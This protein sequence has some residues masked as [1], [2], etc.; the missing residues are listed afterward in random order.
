MGRARPTHVPDPKALG[1]RLRALREARG[2]SLRQIAFPGCSPSYLSRVESGDRVASLTIL[3]ELARRLGTTIE[4]LLGRSIDGRISDGDLA[5][6]EV[7]ARM[8][9]PKADEDI[10]SLLSGARSLGD[11]RAESRL[12]EFQ[13]LLALDRRDEARAVEL[14]EQARSTGPAASARERPALF[15][16]LGRAYTA[17]G[18]LIQAASV[19]QTAFDQVCEAPPDAALMVQFGSYLADAYTD[20][21]R[22]SDAET[23]LGRVLRHDRD[24][25]SADLVQLDW[26]LA[27]TYAEQGESRVAEMYAH[28]VLARME[29]GEEL[30]ARGHAHL[31]IAG[32]LLDQG[33]L[34]E[35]APHLEQAERLF[36]DEAPAELALLAYER[37]RAAL[38]AGDT[39]AAGAHAAA[40]RDRTAE[41]EPGAAGMANALL[42]EIALAEG[43]L[44]DAREL[45]E[46]GIRQMTDRAAPPH[47]ARAYDTLSRIEEEAGNLEAALEALRNRPAVPTAKP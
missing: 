10:E 42:S 39:A 45:C 2:L 30:R 19:L 13:G 27:R 40:M 4:E 47:V 12:L 14:L 44:D 5:A 28:R 35:A 37:G 32:V 22:F 23:V 25:D 7:A 24:V 31:L 34:D 17:T 26:S 18:D 21:G 43:R 41:S 16:A 33:Q 3:A 1:T 38:A 6:A 46:E 15:R 36:A 11:T 20:R 8:G 9:A 29:R